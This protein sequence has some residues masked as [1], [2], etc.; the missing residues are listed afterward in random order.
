MR[1]ER[2]KKQRERN[3]DKMRFSAGPGSIEENDYKIGNVN[4]TVKSRFQKI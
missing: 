2:I 3:G 1:C 4:F